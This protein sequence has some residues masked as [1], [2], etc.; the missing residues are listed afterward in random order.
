MCIV[1][2]S[3]MLK[4]ERAKTG[5]LMLWKV[6]K[7]DNRIGLW[8]STFHD[9]KFCRGNNTAII[10]TKPG[11]FHCFFTRKAARHYRQM[12]NGH[13]WGECFFKMKIIRVFVDRKN[14]VDAGLDENSLKPSISVSQMEI[15]SLKHQR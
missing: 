6:I 12:R 11:Q 9:S 7:K 1:N 14:I 13:P 15:K 2:D 4:K 5:R 10:F 8:N 3:E